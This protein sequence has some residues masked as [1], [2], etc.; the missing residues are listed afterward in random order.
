M[1]QIN[2]PSASTGH[3]RFNPLEIAR[4]IMRAYLQLSYYA[5]NRGGPP[6]AKRENT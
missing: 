4:G 5:N 6:W 2:Q 3:K 1:G